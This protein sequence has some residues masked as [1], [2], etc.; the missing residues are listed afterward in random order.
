MNTSGKRLNETQTVTLN[1][2][3]AKPVGVTKIKK[4]LIK[5]QNQNMMSS[6]KVLIDI[7]EPA[8]SHIQTNPGTTKYI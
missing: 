2:S 7:E 1:K 8:I 4:R 5:L 3:A 6:S